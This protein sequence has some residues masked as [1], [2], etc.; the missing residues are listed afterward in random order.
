M[1]QDMHHMEAG[2]VIYI[3][4]GTL[5]QHKQTTMIVLTAT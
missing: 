1:L 4:V 2:C 3:K 5:D